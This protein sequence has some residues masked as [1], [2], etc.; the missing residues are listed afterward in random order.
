MKKIEKLNHEEVEKF[1]YATNTS[2]K[3]PSIWAMM[4]EYYKRWE[5]KE[6]QYI[7]K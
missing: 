1:L 3:Y 6:S 5:N 2:F 4:N 7:I